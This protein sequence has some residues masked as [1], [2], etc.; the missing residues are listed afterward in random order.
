[1]QIDSEGVAM[2]KNREQLRLKAY[3]DS[4]GVW[5]IGWGCTTYENGARVKAGDQITEAR[6]QQLLAF[7][8]GVAAAAVSRYVTAK[9]NQGQFNALL[10]F[11]YNTGGLAFGNSTLCDLVNANPNDTERIS[12]EFL[13]WQYV[14][15][16]GKKVRS[17]GLVN[18]R[19]EEIEMYTSG[20]LKKKV[21]GSGSRRRS[22]S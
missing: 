4:A 17:Q 14:T 21:N 3:Q 7:H 2:L 10:S 13:K 11:A 15:V 18:R 6:A 22:L 12:A 1:M 8:I 5:T 19:Y 20:S 16:N 9:L